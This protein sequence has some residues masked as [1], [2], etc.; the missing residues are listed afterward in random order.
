MTVLFEKQIFSDW[1]TTQKD[2]QWRDVFIQRISPLAG[3]PPVEYALGMYRLASWLIR[4]RPSA[5]LWVQVEGPGGWYPGNTAFSPALE[6]QAADC[7]NCIIQPIQAR[8]V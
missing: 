3:L 6:G 2:G 7:C 4:K 8:P 5:S 1:R